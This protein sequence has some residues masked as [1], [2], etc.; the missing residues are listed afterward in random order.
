MNGIL[1]VSRDRR[2]LLLRP[3]ESSYWC[4]SAA[5]ALSVG[6][7]LFLYYTSSGIRQVYTLVEID[8]QVSEISCLAHSLM[9]IT[10]RLLH[11][12]DV[13]ITAK[14]LREHPVLGGCAAVGRNFQGTTF[15]LESGEVDALLGVIRSINPEV[16]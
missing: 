13:P 8:S 5:H 14:Q 3:G 10:T 1:G 9:T 15:R 6:D 16:T 7:Y 12:I 11:S 2:R 4:A